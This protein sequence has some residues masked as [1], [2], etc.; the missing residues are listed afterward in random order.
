MRI[1]FVLSF[2]PISSNKICRLK[3]D[4]CTSTIINNNP[5]WSLVVSMDPTASRGAF[6]C[7]PQAC[8][9]ADRGTQ[10]A[11]TDGGMPELLL[12]SPAS[13]PQDYRCQQYCTGY[14]TYYD[15]GTTGTCG[16]GGVSQ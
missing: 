13:S 8:A 2:M 16:N 6:S 15:I 12:K 1:F 5:M 9:L 10:Q 4:N 7:E 11:H 14:R 3:T